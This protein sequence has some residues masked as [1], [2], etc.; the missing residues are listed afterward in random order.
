M[1]RM[2]FLLVSSVCF[3]LSVESIDAGIVSYSWT[4]RIENRTSID[5]FGIGGDGVFSTV[6]G[7][8]YELTVRLDDS[9]IGTP[10]S[11]EGRQF[12]VSS[13]ELKIGGID[14]EILGSSVLVFIQRDDSN[15]NDVVYGG[16]FPFHFGGDPVS[17][18]FNGATEGLYFAMRLPGGTFTQADNPPI[19]PSTLSKSALQSLSTN[20]VVYSLQDSLLEVSSVPEPSS[21]I[22]LVT[23]VLCLLG[24]SRWRKRDVIPA[25]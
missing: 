14:A 20:Y 4:G 24:Y 2:A 6:D 11:P 23:G 5:P 18:K 25:A 15:R 17:V 1:N 7:M 21:L 12:A 13:S 8:N 16:A 10:A 9:V 3:T 19:F 22:L